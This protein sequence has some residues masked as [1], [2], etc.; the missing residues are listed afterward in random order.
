MTIVKRRQNVGLV[1]P[2]LL[3]VCRLPKG[4][5]GGNLH[6]HRHEPQKNQG[7]PTRLGQGVSKKLLKAN[8]WSFADLLR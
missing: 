4:Q 1:V 6:G 7:R 3:G 2:P 5:G 8:R